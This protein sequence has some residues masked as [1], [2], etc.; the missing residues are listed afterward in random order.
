MSK[1]GKLPIAIA[2]GVSLAVEGQNVLVKGPKGNT[3]VNKPEG[4]DLEIADGVATVSAK[5]QNDKRVR[6]LFGMF[7]ANLANAVKGVESGFEKKLEMA[8][9]GYRSQMQGADL[10][11]SVGFSHPVKF[12][13]KTG[14]TLSVADNVISV[15]GID[16]ALVGE[17][18]AE[19]RSVRPPEPYK[20][21]GIKYQ[22]EYVRR[23][24]GKA[25]KAAG[26]TK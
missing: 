18:A 13:P 24:A 14:I 3:S 26:A 20:G 19:I 15:A 17:M 6:S 23:K 5:E 12:S 4:I 10:V 16:K 9:V 11:L 7:R 25:A 2:Q 8:G 22:G 1:I 21:K